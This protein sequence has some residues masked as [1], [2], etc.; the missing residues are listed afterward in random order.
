MDKALDML[1]K[2]ASEIGRTAQEA[3]PLLV[4]QEAFSSGIG[5]LSVGFFAGISFLV[6]LALGVGAY[7][8]KD[9]DFLCFCIIFLIGAIFLTFITGNISVGYFHPEATL[10][11]DLLQR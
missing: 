1:D 7:V 2:L 11:R 9:G 6:A 8:D 4:A 3:W 5:A 10:I